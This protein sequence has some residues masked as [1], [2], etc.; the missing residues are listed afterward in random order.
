MLAETDSMSRHPAPAQKRLD[1]AAAAAE[2]RTEGVLRLL[3]ALLILLALSVVAGWL[4]DIPQLKSVF[5][6]TSTMK[7]N[8]ALGFA[9]TGSGLLLA[10]AD[11]RAFR[12]VGGGLGSLLTLLGAATLLQYVVPVDL[13]IDQAVVPDTGTLMGSGFPGRMSPITTIAWM[14]LGSAILLLAIATRR[15]EVILAH[16]M[17]MAAG[18]VGILGVGGYA[19]GAEAFYGIGFYT[20][21]AVHTAAGLLV[22]SAAALM[23]RAR[24]GWL[25]P[26]V[27]SPAALALLSRLIPLALG[28]PILLGFV[29][30]GGVGAGIYNASFGFALFIPT[31]SVAMALCALWVAGRQR[32][33]EQERLRYQRH[34]QLVVAELNHRVKN[35]LAIIQSFAHQS[36]KGSAS[37]REAAESFEGRLAALAAAHRLLTEESWDNIG[38]AE[39]IADAVHPHNDTG[40]RF[41]VEGPDLMVSP[42]TAITLAMTLHEL[43]TN[44][45]KYGAL[46]SATGYVRLS[47]SVEDGKF[48]LVWK[49]VDG[50]PCR[51]PKRSG[52]G[53]RMLRR[54]LAAELG[55]K[56]SLHYEPDGLRYEVTAPARDEL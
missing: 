7:F 53:T 21:I 5:P 19:F 10:A 9:L 36:L 50:P 55:G 48:R 51:D 30:M 34:L 13:G 26:Y 47:W 42:K 4:L 29:I 11:T 24:E 52:F 23:T 37:P 20:L 16:S 44:S 32:E 22:A 45:T 2:R 35:T 28:V 38:L 56:A 14:L 49:D 46:G 39:L 25:Q 41:A 12:L 8:T 54:A 43:A 33:V 27:G 18:V 15:A 1:Q 40:T 31:A 3:C 6:R 17:A